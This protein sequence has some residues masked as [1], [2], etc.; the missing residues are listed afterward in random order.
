[1]SP[2]EKAGKPQQPLAAPVVPGSVGLRRS[3]NARSSRLVKSPARVLVVEDQ[4]DVRRLLVTALQIEGHIVDEAVDAH[5]GLKRL[6]QARYD[7]VLSDYAMPGGTGMW[8]L[9][10]A[11]CRGLLDDTVPM[12]VTAHPDVADLADIEVI[13]KPF[14][15]DEFLERV[16]RVLGRTSPEP[17]HEDTQQAGARPAMSPRVELVLYVSSTSPASMQARR[18]LEQVLARFESSQ[19][20]FSVCDLVKD[21][22]AGAADR[23]AFT[24]T[25]VKHFPEPRVWVIGNFRD[26]EVIADLLNVSGVD[27]KA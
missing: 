26:Q 14:D 15:L 12:I 4:E 13:T 23:V 18:N 17:D 8:M 24:P 16:R 1:M 25:L 6:H 11:E 20:K 22:M 27:A 10:E 3:V 5:D 9:R 21:P 19:I 2:R 7:L